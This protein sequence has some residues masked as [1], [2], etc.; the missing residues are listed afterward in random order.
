MTA[1]DVLLSQGR[2]AVAGIGGGAAAASEPQEC[3][4][5]RGRRRVC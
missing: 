2:F 5:P 4:Y 1:H 3:V